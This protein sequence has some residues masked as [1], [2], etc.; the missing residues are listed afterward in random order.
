MLKQI[1]A[2][3]LSTD[4]KKLLSAIGKGD[5]VNTSCLLAEGINLEYDFSDTINSHVF[6]GN[7]PLIDAIMFKRIEVVKFLLSNGADSN[8]KH[9]SIGVTPLHYAAFNKNQEIAFY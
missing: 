4:Q 8:L 3:E 5:S 1:N 2:D 6:G 9:A 7:T